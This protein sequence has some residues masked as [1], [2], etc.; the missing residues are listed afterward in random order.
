M[1][2]RRRLK[3]VFIFIQT[4]LRFALSRK[5]ILTNYI[6]IINHKIFFCLFLCFYSKP[7]YNFDEKQCQQHFLVLKG[8]VALRYGK[9]DSIVTAFI[10]FF[11]APVEP[12]CS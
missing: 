2:E 5:I 12:I 7:I 11:T 6:E 8:V 1:I 10:N 3:N 4:V 9:L